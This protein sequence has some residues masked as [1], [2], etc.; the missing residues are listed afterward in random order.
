MKRLTVAAN[1]LPA[2]VALALVL[3]PGTALSAPP[4]KKTPKPAATAAAATPIKMDSI[5]PQSSSVGQLV[6]IQ[7]TGLDRPTAV[8]M[9]PFAAE[10]VEQTP[11]KLVF[12][13]PPD[14]DSPGGY[15]APVTLVTPGQPVIKSP[16]SIN[17]RRWTMGPEPV[18][19][20]PI[21]MPAMVDEE[22][23]VSA[24]KPKSWELAVT[25]VMTLRIAAAAKGGEVE[26]KLEPSDAP[27]KSASWKSEAGALEWKTSL[28]G[29][30]E[31]H[32]S[33]AKFRRVRLTLSTASA[34]EVA[35]KVTVGPAHST[36]GLKAPLAP[37]ATP[38]K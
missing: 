5:E 32:I 25:P 17:T 19:P 31:G 14:P 7:G 24:G 15:Q 2:G 21:P 9:G 23:R 3:A 28:A 10:I 6:T 11:T 30:A 4:A 29:L 26:A 12:R 16:V 33:S 8:L 20:T 35:V 13:I 22:V 37:L 36:R 18:F 34:S 1:V 27:G 38:A